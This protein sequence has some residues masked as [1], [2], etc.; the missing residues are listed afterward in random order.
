MERQLWACV[1]IRVICFFIFDPVC[2]RDP[3]GFPRTYSNLCVAENA[4][5]VFLRKGSCK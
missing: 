2:A 3:R 1:K 4:N 5:A